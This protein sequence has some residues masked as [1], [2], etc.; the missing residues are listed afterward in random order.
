MI[1][2]QTLSRSDLS[3]LLRIVGS[4]AGADIEAI[5]AFE[6]SHRRKPA[7]IDEMRESVARLVAAGYVKQQGSRYYG[8]PEIQTAF[9]DEVRNCRDTIEEFDVLKGVMD[10]VAGTRGTDRTAGTAGTDGT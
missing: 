7:T 9:L 2:S 10:R 1:Q 5:A 6:R 8:A 4:R 3:I